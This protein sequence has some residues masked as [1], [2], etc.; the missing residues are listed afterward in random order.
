[1]PE[2]LTDPRWFVLAGLVF[3]AVAIG[4]SLLKRLPI[5]GAVLYLVI[6]VGAGP[7]G[8]GLVRLDPVAD[9][10]C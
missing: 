3:V 5:T 8:L 4:G 2:E 10:S 1:M 9:S 6:G 7:L